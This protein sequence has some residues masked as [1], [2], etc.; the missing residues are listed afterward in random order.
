MS[1]V[2]GYLLPRILQY[3]L[4]ILVG[5][6]IVF[7]ATRLTPTSPVEQTISRI[8]MQGTYLD[9]ETIEEFKETLRELYGLK[10]NVFQQY[11]GFWKRLLTGR[12]GPS[13]THFPTPVM[14]LIRTSL[15]WTIG[16]LSI[17]TIMAWITGS[18]L[19]GVAQYFSQQKWTSTLETFIM[20][21]RPMPYYIMGLLIL[22]VFA[23]FLPLF[24]VSGAYSV[25]Q[26]ISLNWSFLV[27]VLRHGT[28][29]AL[30][31]VLVG[32]GV[33][34]IQIK[35]VASNVVTEDY[36]TYTQAAGLRNEKIIFSYVMRNALL[37]QITG[38]A[39]ALGQLLSGAMVVE[40]VFSYPGVGMLLY[41]AIAEG[42]YNL[43]MGITVLSIIVIA[44][45]VLIIDLVYPLFDPR[46]RYR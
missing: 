34:F 2:K 30:S 27:S 12:F 29:P 14:E 19:G 25:G 33:W 10:G 3:L 11:L 9:P 35:S 1:F 45:G 31:L 17:S 21:V 36:V 24:P 23:Y 5:T 4:V 39:L 6:S 16:L 42:D 20:A 22:I 15:P 40:Y 32:V 41:R 8:S 43:T 18:I 46:V 7:I 26:K 37:P 44:T 38:L 28:L 13:F